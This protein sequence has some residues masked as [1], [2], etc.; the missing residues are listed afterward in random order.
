MFDSIESIIIIVN[1]FFTTLLATAV[2]I[3]SILN[4]NTKLSDDLDNIRQKA[5]QQ[6]RELDL[7]II[8]YE[9][10]DAYT[11]K[12][13]VAYKQLSAKYKRLLNLYNKLGE[14]NLNG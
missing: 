2:F 5:I 13:V 12:I 8:K 3:N 9:Q 14:T 4:R 11:K 1:M 6:Q 7:L 10:L